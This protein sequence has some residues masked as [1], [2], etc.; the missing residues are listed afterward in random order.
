MT[1]AN[2]PLLELQNNVPIV[3]ERR[4]LPKKFGTI[5]VAPRFSFYVPP[6]ANSLTF[7]ISNS[8]L[9]NNVDL[10][11]KF[12]TLPTALNYDCRSTLPDSNETC[13]IVNPTH[14]YWYVE[15]VPPG[16]TP[17]IDPPPQGPEGDEIPSE[18]LQKLKVDLKAS[19]TTQ[20]SAQRFSQ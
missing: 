1:D 10:Y 14:G 19:Y 13:T 7:T 12:G 6:G 17:G 8:Q 2:H 20:Q 11:V 4:V 9:G 5:I 18:F 16:L 3:A 15:P